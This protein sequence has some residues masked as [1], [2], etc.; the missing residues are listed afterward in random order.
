MTISEDQIKALASDLKEQIVGD[1]K[2]F[3]KDLKDA[4]KKF[5]EDVAERLAKN[6]FDLK[7]GDDD[8]KPI[9]KENI[10]AL[11]RGMPS[12]LASSSIEFVEHGRDQ[13]STI[14]KTI[15]RTVLTMALSVA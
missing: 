1:S 13:V 10:E 12:R 6:Y 8:R 11:N 2:D 9:V 3:I 7:F 4:D 14:L 15:G 5:F